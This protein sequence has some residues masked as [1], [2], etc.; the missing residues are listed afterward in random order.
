VTPRVLSQRASFWV[1]ASVAAIALWTSAAPSVTYPLYAREWGLTP[2]VTT[3]IFAVYPI[4]LVLALAIFG[5]ISDYIGRRGAIVLGLT[6]SLIGVLLFAIAPNVVWVFIG[7]GFMGLGVALSLS[8]ATAAMVELSAPEKRKRASA[9]TTASTAAGLGL[10]TLL[11][12]FL[13]EYAPFPTH[14]NFWVLSVVILGVLAAAWFLP[15]HSAAEARGRWRP[16]VV[17]I[18]VGTRS[19][20]ALGAVAVITAYLLGVVVLSL[21]ANIA[22]DLI[23]STNALVNGSIMSLNAVAIGIAAIVVRNLRPATMILGGGIAA[24][25][26]M[27]TLVLSSVE[28]SIPL[29]LAAAIVT[30]IGY[31]LLF[32]G[33]LG[34][35]SA[36]APAHHRAGTLSAVY[37]IAYFFQGVS[38]IFLGSVATAS[39]L[40]FA[41]EIGASIIGLFSV[42]AVVL[43]LF[44][45]R[46]AS[47]GATATT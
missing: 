39:G 8:P 36:S 15:R 16:R 9:I 19:Y 11:G 35:V 20:F 27:A 1:A 25:V 41:V 42:A 24:F 47:A 32:A 7:R 44:L 5:N 12:G 18:P 2:T 33:G 29:F 28:H 43:A 21:G 10:A 40:E 22:Q 23:G 17:T 31:S 45:R 38:A 6:A 34:V 26:G 14:L 30:G 3:T 37:L 13:I 4:V 46:P